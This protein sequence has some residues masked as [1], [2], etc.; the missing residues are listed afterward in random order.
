MKAGNTG[1]INIV[2]EEYY[3][4]SLGA[5]VAVNVDENFVGNS[6]VLESS[7]I[8]ESTNNENHLAADT[9]DL[10]LEPN[11]ISAEGVLN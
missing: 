4:G 8:S 7:L 2:L 6:T 9:D 11:S 10:L 1:I 3:E 5:Q